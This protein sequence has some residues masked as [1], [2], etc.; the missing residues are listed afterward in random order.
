MICDRKGG[1]TLQLEKLHFEMLFNITLPTFGLQIVNALNMI[2]DN[3]S[4]S[5]SFLLAP[6]GA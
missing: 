5:P 2:I 6:T 1:L 4:M 3:H